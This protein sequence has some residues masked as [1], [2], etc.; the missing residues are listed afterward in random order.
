MITV[1]SKIKSKMSDYQKKIREPIK[2][3]KVN[4]TTLLAS[5]LL[6]VVVDS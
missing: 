5:I 3:L 4:I 6:N 1:Q 2:E